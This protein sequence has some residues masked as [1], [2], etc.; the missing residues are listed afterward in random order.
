[1]TVYASKNASRTIPAVQPHGS[2]AVT[3]RFEFDLSAVLLNADVVKMG[4]LPANCKVVD[5]TL[6]CDDIDTGSTGVFDFGILTTA[7]VPAMDT[8]ASGGAAWV[9]ASTLGQAGGLVRALTK[10]HTRMVVSRTADQLIG[11]VVMGNFTATATG[12]IG[13]TL[14]YIAA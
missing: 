12:K 10:T 8:I 7:P 5:W 3:V 4:W 14:T 13:A 11:L 2:E 1:M 9:A 6:D